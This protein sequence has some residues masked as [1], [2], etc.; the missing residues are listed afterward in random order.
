M[1]APIRQRTTSV[2]VVPRKLRGARL[3]AHRHLA[4]G[5]AAAEA[6]H[7]GERGAQTPLGGRLGPGLRGKERP[8]R[9]R[10]RTVSSR[11][12]FTRADAHLRR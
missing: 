1:P 8:P 9:Q 11:V 4:G 5:L 6:A 2:A 7:D 10:L 3:P 12:K